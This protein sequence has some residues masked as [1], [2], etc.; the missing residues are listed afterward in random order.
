MV[1]FVARFGTVLWGAA[2]I[3]IISLTYPKILSERHY[4]LIGYYKVAKK[5]A[6]MT[7]PRMLLHCLRQERRLVSVDTQCRGLID[8]IAHSLREWSSKY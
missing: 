8:V 6:S 1:S 3:F 2:Y 4:G 7:L 5:S